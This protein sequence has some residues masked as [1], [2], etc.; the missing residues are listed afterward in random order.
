MQ[1]ELCVDSAAVRAKWWMEQ[2]GSEAGRGGE[3][4]GAAGKSLHGQLPK[5]VA[6]VACNKAKVCVI[7]FYHFLE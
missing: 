7:Y 3:G 2:P 4:D 6:C 5:N 1:A